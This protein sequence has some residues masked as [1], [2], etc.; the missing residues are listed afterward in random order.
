MCA[1]FARWFSLLGLART[2]ELTRLVVESDAVRAELSR[3]EARLEG[4]LDGAYDAA[5]IIR[6]HQGAPPVWH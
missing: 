6:I 3:L 4:L 5:P 1:V 2:E